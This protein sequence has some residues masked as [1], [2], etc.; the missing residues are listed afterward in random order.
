LVDSTPDD[1]LQ[2]TWRLIDYAK[3][4]DALDVRTPHLVDAT[5]GRVVPLDPTH[6]PTPW[7]IDRVHWSKDG[8]YATFVYNQR[9]HEVVR[10]LKVD[11]AT[12][13]VT[14]VIEEKH[15][16]FIDYVNA[17][18][19]DHLPETGEALWMSERDGWRHVWLLDL[20]AGRIKRQVTRGPW[21]VRRI[22]KIDPASREIVFFAG[23]IHPGRDLYFSTWRAP[24]SIA[25]GRSS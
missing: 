15:G 2:P 14:V 23:G 18:R 25:T 10:L 6:F 16:A 1:Q 9:G 7:S 12:A 17:L 22:E 21:V 3:P 24:R 19:I 4:G 5:T 11:A 8:S 20:N 13:A